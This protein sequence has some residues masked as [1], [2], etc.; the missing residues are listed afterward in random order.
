MTPLFVILAGG[1]GKRFAPFTTDKTLFPLLGKPLIQHTF[2]QIERI[3]GRK[4]LVITN[5]ENQ[6]Y[7]SNYQS[8]L[9]IDCVLQPKSLGMG[10]ALLLA[11]DKIGNQPCIVM[12]AIDMVDDMLLID[13]LN[14]S[15]DSYAVI[16]GKKVNSYF[17][18]GYLELNQENQSIRSIIEKPGEGNEPSNLINLVFH[19]FSQPQE[20]IELLRTTTTHQ[21]DLYERALDELMRRQPVSFLAYNHYWQAL[22]YSYMVLDMMSLFLRTK[23][24]TF[25][26]DSAK[27]SAS[28]VISG[29]VYISKGVTIYENAVVKGPVFLGENVIV[30]DGASIRESV[31]EESAVIGFGSEVTRSYIGPRCALH[32]NYIGDSVLES[33]VNPSYGT[34]TANWRLDN[35]TVKVEYPSG[36]VDTGK[37]KMGALIAKDVFCGIHCSIMPGV[38]IGEGAKIHPNRVLYENVPANATY[39]E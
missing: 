2:E 22:K 5:K 32:H 30:G 21:D 17:P 23:V 29:P 3:G 20:F 12:N 35:G 10:D 6:D 16:T 15:K 4:I 31:V 26:A 36:K 7:I 33:D 19:Y 24:R 8:P 14:K 18:G 34:C 38:M 1:Q 13:L 37:L 27:I 39:K 9:S 11:A 25:T 28:A